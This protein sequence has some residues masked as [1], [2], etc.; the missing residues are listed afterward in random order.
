MSKGSIRRPAQIPPEE[1]ARRWEEIFG[2]REPQECPACGFDP[3]KCA[4]W[5]D[6]Y[7]WL[8]WQT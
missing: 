4:A 3:C 8:T 1:E 6:P 7:E 5:D 2:K